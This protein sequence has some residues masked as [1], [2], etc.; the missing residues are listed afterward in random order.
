MWQCDLDWTSVGA[1]RIA[2]ASASLASLVGLIES[3]VV[4]L[5]LG[6]R[7]F[8]GKVDGLLAFGR[9][10]WGVF[11]ECACLLDAAFEKW[12]LVLLGGLP[13][14]NAHAAICEL[15]WGVFGRALAVE[16]AARKRAS[17]WRLDSGDY[18]KQ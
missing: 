12:A 9:W 2:S 14:R 3:R 16:E 7:L 10:L 11:P 8:K 15:G 6:L 4:P 13:W 17:L 1:S 5:A 18:Y